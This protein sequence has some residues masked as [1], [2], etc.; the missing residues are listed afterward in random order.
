M[1]SHNSEKMKWVISQLRGAIHGSLF[2]FYDYNEPWI[3]Q[4]LKHHKC[5]SQIENEIYNCGLCG[6]NPSC[7]FSAVF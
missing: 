5:L 7:L 3:V 6:I 4:I 2:L 1:N